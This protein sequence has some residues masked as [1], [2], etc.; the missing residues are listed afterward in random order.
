QQKLNA[1]ILEGRFSVVQMNTNKWLRFNQPSRLPSFGESCIENE[2][3]L[4]LVF[5]SISWDIHTLCAVASLSRRFCAIARRI[6]WRRLC[7]N[8]APGMVAALS[9]ADPTGR[10]DGG[11]HALAKLMFFCGGGE[12]TRYFNLSQPSLGHFACESRFSKTSGRFFL[13]KNCR[14]DLLYMSDP[15]EHHAVGGDEHLGVFRGVFREFMRS[16]TREC[17]VRRQA[18]LEEKVRCPY[19]GGRVWSMTAARLVPKSAA[20]RLGSRDSG[21][22]F[23]VCVNGH[24]HGT[25]WLIPLSSEEE[26]DD[27]SDGSVI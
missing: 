15:C 17:L 23:F 4:V 2:R 19:C 21:L 10:I 14:R 3:V 8:R 11:W 18:A 13:P 25:C 27:N 9:G 1:S 22:E 5:E 20:R 24:L 7:V 12:S 6:L 26:D 16:K